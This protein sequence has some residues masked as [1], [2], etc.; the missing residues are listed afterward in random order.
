MRQIGWLHLTDLHVG[1]PREA[2]RL[3]AIE[4]ALLADLDRV[5]AKDALLPTGLAI[6]VV[7]FTGDIAFRGDDREFL[8]ATALLGRILRGVAE[9]NA[10]CQ[11]KP[12]NLMPLLCV[13]PGNHDLA[14][15]VPA[16][17]AQIRAA[18]HERTAYSPALWGGPPELVRELID[19][20][21]AAWRRWLRHP[22]PFAP[23][24]GAGLLPG[25][26]NCT[27]HRSGL[28]LGVLGLNSA[29]LHLDDTGDG[30]LHVDL[31]QA[32][33]LIG[34]TANW[35]REHDATVL[36]TH[37]PPS[38]LTP[39]AQRILAEDIRP[40]KT[41]DLHLYGH[42]HVG[43]HEAEPGV[44]GI[45]HFVEGRSLFG[46]E[47]GDFPRLHGYNVGRFFVEGDRRRAQIWSRRGWVAS[48]GWRFGPAGGR[49]G[50]WSVA[51]DLGEV[52]Q[53]APRKGAAT[54][55]KLAEGIGEPN[56]RQWSTLAGLPRCGAPPI[57]PRRSRGERAHRGVA[58]GGSSCRR[59]CP[60]PTTNLSDARRRRSSS[61]RHG[62]M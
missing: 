53:P 30:R 11:S 37:H 16:K 23:R 51:I 21:F 49:S 36:L 27:I 62:R 52:R 7:F 1:Q 17:A 42:A 35:V 15:P 2:G 8:R 24:S 54:V 40:S 10:R 18:F 33:A 41:I 34:A 3:P 9:A 61:R 55:A 58:R 31:S 32:N 59:A 26:M 43:R 14:R 45:R 19:D 13:V 5:I 48:D 25:D 44:D 6:D 46:A 47:E 28:S 38:S 4:T 50:H 39:V 57:R 29:W 12:D 20:A 56:P 60:R 22:L